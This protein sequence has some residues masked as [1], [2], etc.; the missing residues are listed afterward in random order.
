VRNWPNIAA[1]SLPTFGLIS[2]WETLVR[3]E[4]GEHC[5]RNEFELGSNLVRVQCEQETKFGAERKK[6]VSLP[7]FLI[8]PRA[9]FHPVGSNHFRPGPS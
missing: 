8:N 4:N 3:N 2:I 7:R 5:A 1:S 9:F 6:D